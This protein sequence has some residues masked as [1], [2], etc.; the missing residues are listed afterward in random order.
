[1]AKIITDFLDFRRT[2]TREDERIFL[3]ASV[4]LE[5]GEIFGKKL[6][7]A[8]DSH[9]IEL[10]CL[11]D[12]FG[13]FPPDESQLAWFFV[14]GDEGAEKIGRDTAATAARAR[15]SPGDSLAKQV[16]LTEN[17]RKFWRQVQR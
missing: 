15:N 12:R 10:D 7:L 3:A 5:D 2:R 17:R 9:T 8:R 14:G 11:C 6:R 13:S 1:L 16:L 4:R